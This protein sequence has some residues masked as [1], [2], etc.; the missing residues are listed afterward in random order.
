M[1]TAIISSLV[2]G[3][4][5]ANAQLSIL[6]QIGLEN[7]RT[8]IQYNELSSFAPL[9]RHFSP[10]L[11]VRM[12]YKFKKGH[13]PFVGLGTNRS[14]VSYNFS[15]PETG[16]NLYTAS[17]NNLR[18]RVEGGYQFSTKKIYFNKSKS[19]NSATNK[20]KTVTEIYSVKK[21]C[22]GE[23]IV[24][25]RCGQSANKSQL[26]K[27]KDKGWW[28]SIQPLA[29]AA[30]IPDDEDDDDEEDDANQGPQAG[31]KY[32]AGNWNS[33][34]I[35]GANFE[36]GKNAH[37]KFTIGLNYLKG[38]GLNKTTYTTLVGSKTTTTYL[39]SRTSN[40]TLSAGIPITLSKNK[41][42]R[43]VEEKPRTNQSKCAEYKTR[44][45]RAI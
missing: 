44:C 29:G 1:R 13:G 5:A 43:K 15:D 9:G 14:V 40:W 18:L 8:T 16:M 34:L 26:A 3:A 42:A 19:S 37:R 2:F 41:S 10:Q 6:P 30:F 27:A 32:Q 35:M 4:V 24:K 20:N 7:S 36:F 25:S 11:S 38:L 21:T 22:G 33:A 17:A 12:D 39:S 28:V 45:R 23:Y 31:Y